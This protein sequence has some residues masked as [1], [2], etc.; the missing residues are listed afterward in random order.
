MLNTAAGGVTVIPLRPAPMTTLCK[1]D[2]VFLIA[3]TLTSDRQPCLQTDPVVHVPS[4]RFHYGGNDPFKA[5][6]V[7]VMSC[8]ASIFPIT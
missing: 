6:S 7:P 8:L 4:I 1:G 2:C 5:V 3:G